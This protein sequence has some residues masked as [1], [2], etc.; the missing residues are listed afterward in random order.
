M[1]PT[2]LFGDLGD[3]L[4][5]AAI[6]AWNAKHLPLSTDWWNFPAFA[7][8]SGVTAFTE[9]LLGAYPLTSP[10]VW[11]TGNP[12]LAYNVLQ[13][14]TL[15]L[16]RRR[17]LRTRARAH[18]IVASG[19]SSADSPSR[20]RRLRGEHV[21]HIQMLMAFGMPF[22]LYGLHRYLK[23][24][25]ARGLV[26]FGLGWL[27]VALSNAYM[28]VFFPIL[29]ALWAMWFLK[30]TDAGRWLAIVVAAG[31]ATLPVVPLLI[32]Y[33]LRQAAYGLFRG[34]P[35]SLRRAP[36]SSRSRALII[37][38]SCGWAGCRTP[39]TSSRCSRDSPSSRSSS[40]ASRRVVSRDHRRWRRVVLFYFA[41]AVVMWT[42]TLGPEVRW[43]GVRVPPNYGPYWLLLHLPGVQ[44]I[45]V[46]SRAWL[47]AT[48]CLA[49]CAGF[50]AAWLATRRRTRWVIAPLIMLIV[51]EGWF[52]GQTVQVADRV[53]RCLSR[54]A[55]VLD[56][57]ISPGFGNADA[58]Y[59]AVLG[60]YR[61]VNGY[62][63]YTP[64][65]FGAL[66]NALADHRPEAFEPF[67]RRADLYVVARPNL[68]PQFVTWLES[69][70]DPQHL[71]DLGRW[72][73][74]RLAASGRRPAAAA[75]AAV[76]QAGRD[77]ADDSRIRPLARV[78]LNSRSIPS[79][80]R[81]VPCRSRPSGRVCPTCP[82]CIAIR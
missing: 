51:A 12:V 6:L 4:L 67:R 57:P 45:R 16:E 19:P 40:L 56:L 50:G 39:T 75:A 82:R 73:L 25:A 28:L 41:G 11:F 15:P 49:V 58:Q 9:H 29:V 22:A 31:V 21:A 38:P 2:H 1:L 80:S 3:P 68:E 37:E 7:P 60:D 44:S 65:H 79:R 48:L 52:V 47:P 66:R 72:K 46:P 26:W 59:L 62:S 64:S 74:Y 35:K 13:L 14:L 18:R 32:G 36:A 76:A 33:H 63:G 30:R 8:L 42:F 54:Q 24:G 71:I 43:S 78:P 23:Y 5:N 81:A 34:Y 55:Q 17:C 53:A 77:A 70:H 27:S 20:L 69:L 10:I 61:V